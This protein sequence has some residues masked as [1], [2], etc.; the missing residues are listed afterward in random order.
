MNAETL[1]FLN[2]RPTGLKSNE[3]CIGVYCNSPVDVNKA[4]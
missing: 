1:N 4:V 3:N 2:G